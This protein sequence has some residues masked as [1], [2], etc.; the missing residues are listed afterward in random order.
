MS[1]VFACNLN[2]PKSLIH[3]NTETIRAIMAYYSKLN[4]FLLVWQVRCSSLWTCRSSWSSCWCS[5]KTN[6]STGCWTTSCGSKCATQRRTRWV[7][8][9]WFPFLSEEQRYEPPT[10]RCIQTQSNA[11]YSLLCCCERFK[12]VC[13]CNRTCFS[14]IRNTATG[15]KQTWGFASNRLSSN[16]SAHT[17][18][19]LEKYRNLR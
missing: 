19:W 6:P 13:L 12:G 3:L 14:S 4:P 9:H 2:N 16:M 8:L 15:R 5:T 17:H 7:A 11:V 1:I 18:H 10:V